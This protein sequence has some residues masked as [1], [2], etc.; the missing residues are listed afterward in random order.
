MSF[1][2]RSVFFIVTS[3]LSHCTSL[4]LSPI[5]SWIIMKTDLL[6]E[7]ADLLTDCTDSWFRALL[8]HTRLRYAATELQKMSFLKNFTIYFYKSSP[9]GNF[10]WVFEQLSLPRPLE[11]YRREKSRRLYGTRG[12]RRLR[13]ADVTPRSALWQYV[14]RLNS[15]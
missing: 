8:L 7:I 4:F 2:C 11:K 12:A 9:L 14:F 5:L 3:L 6:L 10:S 1:L 13:V 15:S